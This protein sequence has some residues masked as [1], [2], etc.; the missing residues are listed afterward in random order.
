MIVNS[1]KF[2]AI[3]LNKKESEA[4]YKLTTTETAECHAWKN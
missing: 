1:N 2:K 4:K 3:T